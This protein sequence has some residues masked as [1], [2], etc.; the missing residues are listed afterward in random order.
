MIKRPISIYLDSQDYSRM[1]HPPANKPDFYRDLHIELDRLVSDGDVEIRYSAAMISEIAHTSQRAAKY[2]AARAETL[3]S[4]SRGKCLRFWSD[5]LEDEIKHARDPNYVISYNRE[6]DQWFD[7][8]LSGLGNFV[9]RLKKNVLEGLKEKGVNRK[10]RRK[11]GKTDFVR[12]LT[13]TGHGQQLL[14]SIV[15]RINGKYPV[16]HELDRKTLAGYIAGSVGEERFLKYMRGLFADP[17]NL[18]SRIVPE[19]DSQLKLPALVRNQ[20]LTLI[21]GMN[22]ALERAAKLLSS[23][24]SSEIFDTIRNDSAVF[25]ARTAI[26]IRRKTVRQHLPEIG[27]NVSG[28][29][30]DISDNEIDQMSLPTLDT[31]L[32]TMARHLDEVMA[33][34]KAQK[35][36]R[37]FERSD[38]ADL[39]HATYIPYVDVF[40]CDTGWTDRLK[41]CGAKFQTDIVGRIE[42][43]VP[44]VR[45]RLARSAA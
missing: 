6:N 28:K 45:Q 35:P 14:D 40:R 5:I 36:I 37:L 11:A 29:T 15:E 16:E 17:V 33:A 20:G 13:Q 12:L 9:G 41:R 2:S 21:D 44:T 19:H 25:A 43:L 26:N 10:A 4:L 22:P 38:A 42:D 31:L 3:K 39:I 23:L 1:A 8:D 24:P 34:A 32:D 30:L 18:I 7:V 27:E